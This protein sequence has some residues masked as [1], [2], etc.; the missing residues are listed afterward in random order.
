ML[1]LQIS[2]Y[3]TN[4]VREIRGDNQEWI[5]QRQGSN[6]HKQQNADK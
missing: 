6:G 4:K 2:D 5:I 1:M 3:N